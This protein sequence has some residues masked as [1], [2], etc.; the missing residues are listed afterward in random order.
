MA[1]ARDELQDESGRVTGLTSEPG[2]RLTVKR[3]REVVRPP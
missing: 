2:P 3:R 1:K